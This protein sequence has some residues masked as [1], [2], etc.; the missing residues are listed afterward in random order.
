MNGDC[1]VDCCKIEVLIKRQNT[2]C[3]SI[4]AERFQFVDLPFRAAYH[5]GYTFSSSYYLTYKRLC[6]CLV[7]L[8]HVKHALEFV[9]ERLAMFRSIVLALLSFAILPVIYCGSISWSSVNFQLSS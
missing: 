7:A 4:K 8:R 6:Q 5:T 3:G 1:D 9:A 2:A